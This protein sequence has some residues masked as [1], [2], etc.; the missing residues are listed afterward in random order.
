LHHSCWEKDFPKDGWEKKAGRWEQEEGIKVGKKEKRREEKKK[1][2]S[3]LKFKR[4]TTFEKIWRT[5]LFE[6]LV[7]ITNVSSRNLFLFFSRKSSA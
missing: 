6:D 2:S 5:N 7:N 3:G 4:K 1:S